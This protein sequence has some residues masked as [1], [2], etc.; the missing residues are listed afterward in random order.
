MASAWMPV[1][2]PSLFSPCVSQKKNI[3]K[4]SS[5]WAPTNNSANRCRIRFGLFRC[6]CR[7][8]AI[9]LGLTT[10]CLIPRAF[11]LKLGDRA[12]SVDLATLELWLSQL[13]ERKQ[14]RFSVVPRSG[15][16][17]TFW[18]KPFWWSFAGLRDAIADKGGDPSQKSIRWCKPSWLLTT[19]WQ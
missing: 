1:W 18:V 6:P 7:H 15:G 12:D 19:R 4:G 13:I 2:K 3:H 11:C 5:I 16:A 8:E 10:R 9:K 17:T 14:K